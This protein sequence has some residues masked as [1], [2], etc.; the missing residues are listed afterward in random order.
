MWQQF[1][2]LIM[3]CFRSCFNSC[4]THLTD[5]FFT[6]NLSAKMWYTHS[7]D[8]LV[9]SV[10]SCYFSLRS[11]KIILCTFAIITGVAAHI[12][13]P[14][15]RSSSRLSQPN[16]NTVVHLATAEYGEVVVSQCVLNINMNFFCFYTFFMK[17]FITAQIYFFPPSTINTREQKWTSVHTKALH[18]E[19]Q[20]FRCLLIAHLL[21]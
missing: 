15:C 7:D 1:V 20:Y 9:A 12:G 4:G 13:R 8:I 16:L 3:T 17:Y 11:S 21:C 18:P 19:Y 10:M 5:N 2:L 14:F 6:P